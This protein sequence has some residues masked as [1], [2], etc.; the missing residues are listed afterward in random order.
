[1]YAYHNLGALRSSFLVDSVISNEF[2]CEVSEE[3][4]LSQ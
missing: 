4:E 2:S 3:S 1:M